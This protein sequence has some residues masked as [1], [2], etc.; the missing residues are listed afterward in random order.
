MI[1]FDKLPKAGVFRPE[2]Q[3]QIRLMGAKNETA[4]ATTSYTG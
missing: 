1:Q 4:K 3:R 2:K